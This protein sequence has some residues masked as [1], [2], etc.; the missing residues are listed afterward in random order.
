MEAR[1]EVLFVGGGVIGLS[2]AYFLAR[3]GVRVA[4]IDKGELGREASWAGAGIIN[5]ANLERAAGP[6]Q[7]LLGLSNSLWPA[8][9]QDLLE[10][11][12]VDNGY[13]ICGG[14]ELASELEPELFQIWQAEGIRLEPIAAADMQRIESAFED[15]HENGYYLP[16]MAQVRNP[17]HVRALTQACEKLGVEFLPNLP[18]REFRRHGSRIEAAITDRGKIRADRFLIAAGAWSDQVL[19]SLGIAAGVFPVRGQIVLFNPGR[20]VFHTIISRGKCYLVPRTDGRVLA[21]ATEEHVGF[22]KGN[23]PE[24]IARLSRFAHDLVPAL[25]DS[26][27]ETTWSGLRPGVRRELPFLGMVGDFANLYLAAG[28]FRSGLML[29]PGTGWLMSQLL[30]GQAPA[31][32]LEPFAMNPG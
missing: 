32:P 24:A 8:L 3:A 4:I 1:R 5:P 16:D 20:V 19:K 7:R 14:I 25:V 12:G 15:V 21:G 9:T 31:I 26:P 28:H 2:T 22:E 17:W 11:T 30:Q 27:V 13:R 10:R 18:V 23:T 29:S 6:A